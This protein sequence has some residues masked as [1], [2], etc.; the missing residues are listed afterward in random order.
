MDM[1]V[2]GSHGLIGSA[3][4]PAL[5]AAGHRVRR[6]VRSQPG[7][8]D[9]VWDPAGGTI[10]AA[11]LEG[12]D[13]VVHLAGVGIGDK[14][15]TAAQKARILD[16]RVKG[17]ALLATT[18]ARLPTPPR[19]LVSQSAVGYY[20]DRGDE[21][22]TEE[23][24]PGQGFLAGVV[25]AW[26]GAAQPAAEAGVRVVATRSGVVLSAAGGAVKKQLPLFK[27]GLGGP[28]GSGRQWV[29]WIG[30]DD[31]V[32]GILHALATDSLAGP[33][34]LTAPEPVTAKAMA[35]ALG[36]VLHR[37]AVLPVPRPALALVLGSQLTGEMVLASQ[38]A[39]PARLEA[40]GYRFRHPE[41]GAALA[42]VLGRAGSRPA[43]AAG[44]A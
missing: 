33:V 11:G 18:L 9:V 42:A 27:L 3:L 44:G 1:A 25:Q 7:P 19:V 23:S 34:N 4:V 41:V 31:E 20:G 40:S 36:R 12:V 15:W 16:S 37:P 26:E 13:G 32:G 10:D 17:T 38:R 28:L 14:R 2:T 6:L 8:G 43:P 24:S 22:L 35:R 21:V 39:V 5:V 29:S 30:I